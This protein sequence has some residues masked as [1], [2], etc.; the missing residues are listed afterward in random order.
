MSVT[1]ACAHTCAYCAAVAAAE[2][3]ETRKRRGRKSDHRYVRCPNH[4]LWCLTKDEGLEMP[5]S[6]RS[7][8]L[9]GVLWPQ[10]GIDGAWS[11]GER[12]PAW[13]F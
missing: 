12:T 9:A 4:L 13:L 6:Y 2:D 8:G 1:V 3:D 11:P 10:T 7:V 5:S